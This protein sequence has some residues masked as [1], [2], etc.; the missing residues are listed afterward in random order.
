MNAELAVASK[1]PS[2]KNKKGAPIL[3]GILKSLVWTSS[4]P[5]PPSPTLNSKKTPFFLFHVRGGMTV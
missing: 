3:S 5:S 4:V 2:G 1:L